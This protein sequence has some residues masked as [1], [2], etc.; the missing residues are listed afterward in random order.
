M[1]RSATDGQAPIGSI[2]Y[3]THPISSGIRC[4]RESGLE[5][6]RFPIKSRVW[7]L[8]Q[9]LSFSI[10]VMT[11]SAR[12]SRLSTKS[13]VWM[14]VALMAIGSGLD[15][16]TGPLWVHFGIH[17]HALEYFGG[18]IYWLGLSLLLLLIPVAAS[19]PDDHFYLRG[20]C[21]LRAQRVG[22]VFGVLLVVFIVMIVGL[23]LAMRGMGHGV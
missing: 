5:I 23:A 11:A 2:K 3:P 16:I 12:F 20:D 1:S 9:R 17:G 6:S 10:P 14:S 8:M 13:Y 15:A 7:T 19:R 22:F 18:G 4:L 21:K